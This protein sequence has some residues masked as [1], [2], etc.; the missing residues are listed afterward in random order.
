MYV[1]QIPTGGDRNFAY[2]IADDTTGHAAVVDPSFAPEAIAARSK[3][4]G[5]VVRYILITHDHGDHTNGN[6]ILKALTGATVISHQNS[7]IP[8][9]TRVA[10]ED[11]VALGSLLIRVLH[12]PGHTQG[13]VCYHV[14]DAVFTGDTLFVGK[15]G[16]SDLA[17]GA[18]LEFDSLHKKLLALPDETRVFPGHDYGINPTS[19][20]GDE[21]R[22]N[23]FLLQPDLKAFIDLKR[24]WPEYKRIHGIA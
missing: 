21:R 1:E 24:N 9:D 22:T 10:D 12:T 11:V 2:L 18:R 16:G 7:A 3:A 14:E 6:D 4:L 20:I 23:P 17:E 13:H 8:T 15:I 5:F 19:T